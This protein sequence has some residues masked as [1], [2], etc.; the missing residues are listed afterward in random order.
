MVR[1]EEKTRVSLLW[2]QEEK[3]RVSLLWEQALFWP[4]GEGWAVGA[5]GT[6]PPEWWCSP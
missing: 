5:G 3:T 2:E 6:V 4:G 1:E